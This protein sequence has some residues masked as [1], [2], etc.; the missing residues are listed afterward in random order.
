MSLVKSNFR[1]KRDKMETKPNPCKE[2]DNGEI[3]EQGLEPTAP[4]PESTDIL[5]GIRD[6]IGCSI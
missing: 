3:I 4:S 2:D 1:K 6:I 5:A